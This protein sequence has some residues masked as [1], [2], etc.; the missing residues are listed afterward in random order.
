MLPQVATDDD[1]AV[2]ESIDALLSA[3][4][5]GGRNRPKLL[6]LC[7]TGSNPAGT[8]MSEPRRR[9]VY[10]AARRHNLLVLE[11][12]AYWNLLIDDVSCAVSAHPSTRGG[13]GGG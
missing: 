7:P 11:D 4:P 12:D 6:Y 8:T 9:A 2:P 1:G 13:G 3:W 5:E 10:A